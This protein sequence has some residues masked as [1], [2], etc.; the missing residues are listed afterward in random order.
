ME[1][2]MAEQKRMH[3]EQVEKMNEELKRKEMEMKI[4]EEESRNKEHQDGTETTPPLIKGVVVVE[5]NETNEGQVSTTHNGMLVNPDGTLSRTPQSETWAKNR[6]HQLKKTYETIPKMPEYLNAIPGH[7]TPT[8]LDLGW[9]FVGNWYDVPIN[10]DQNAVEGQQTRVGRIEPYIDLNGNIKKALS[11]GID[12][13]NLGPWYNLEEVRK[14]FPKW[15]IPDP[16][17]YYNNKNFNPQ[18]RRDLADNRQDKK[19]I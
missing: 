5:I 12:K 11:Y 13:D 15:E 19:E 8:N 1:K 6:E 9:T 16:P 4:K 17:R 3:E 10:P 14:T 7:P 18:I 2:M